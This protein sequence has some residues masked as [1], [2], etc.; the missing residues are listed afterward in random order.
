MGASIIPQTQGKVE[1]FH[2]TLA[3]ELLCGPLL[4]DLPDCQDAFDRW[5]TQNNQER[6]HEALG[7]AVPLECYTVSPRPCRPTCRR[8]SMDRMTRCGW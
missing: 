3:A 4:R 2:G 6:P 5:R 1:R 7:L 8:S